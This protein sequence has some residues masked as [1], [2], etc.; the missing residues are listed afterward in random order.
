M[1]LACKNITD[2]INGQILFSKSDHVVTDLIF[3]RGRVGAFRRGLKK[4]SIR[5]LPELVDQNSKTPLG[6]AKSSGCFLT[7]DSFDKIC[8]QG[9][10][11]SMR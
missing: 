5:A 4:L 8:S 1:A 11:L 6:V 10:I 9:F 3:L 7:A 2:V